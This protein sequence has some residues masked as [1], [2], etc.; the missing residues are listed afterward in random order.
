MR[1][2]AFNW[3]ITSIVLQAALLHNWLS[4]V[5]TVWKAATKNL[6]TAALSLKY[7]GHRQSEMC[8]PYVHQIVL[9]EQSQTGMSFA[10]DT[11]PE[12]PLGGLYLVSRVDMLSLFP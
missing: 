6:I 3:A 9:S 8:P 4:Q 7:D 11:C 1:I 5:H 12:Y 10:S 2:G